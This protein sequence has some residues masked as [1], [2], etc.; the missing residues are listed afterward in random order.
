MKKINEMP[1]LDATVPVLERQLSEQ[2]EA[3]TSKLHQLITNEKEDEEFFSAPVDYLTKRDLVPFT[4][5]KAT[6]G[7]EVPVIDDTV[8]ADT[9]RRARELYFNR[10]VPGIE[11]MSCICSKSKETAVQSKTSSFTRITNRKET[12]TNKFASKSTETYCVKRGKNMLEIDGRF[13]GPLIDPSV[14][15]DIEFMD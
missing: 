8:F 2:Y 6:N 10:E 4:S 1:I 13:V 3:L 7:M 11:I 12:N 9:I 15:S 5:I 14:F